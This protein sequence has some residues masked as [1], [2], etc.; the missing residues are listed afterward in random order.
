MRATSFAAAVANFASAAESAESTSA[1][2]DNEVWCAEMTYPLMT[3]IMAM[4]Y[5]GCAAQ[6]IVSFP[7]CVVSFFDVKK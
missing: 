5:S 2:S 7:G 4:F 1:V 6:V 3:E